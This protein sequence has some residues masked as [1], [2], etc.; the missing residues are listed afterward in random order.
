MFDAKPAVFSALSAISGVTVSDAYPTDW[1]KLP[2]ISFY[3]IVNSPVY[4]AFPD[5]LTEVNIQIDIWHEKGT[6]AL[7]QEV[8]AAMN[9]IG[10]RRSFA[11]DVPDPSGIKHKT[12]RYRGIIEKSTNL[13]Y[14]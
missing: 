6:G 1:S 13:V 14:Q 9:A 12:M 3:E 11:A 8:E 7:A 5:A 4:S 2:A 10:F